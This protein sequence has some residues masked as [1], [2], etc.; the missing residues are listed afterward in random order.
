M[1]TPTSTAST[2]DPHTTW[3]AAGT[4]AEPQKDDSWIDQTGI[5]GTKTAGASAARVYNQENQVVDFVSLSAT[6]WLPP[7]HAS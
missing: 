6:M 1:M 7:H 4:R 2:A 3:Q 5:P